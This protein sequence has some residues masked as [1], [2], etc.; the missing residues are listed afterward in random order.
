MLLLSIGISCLYWS[1]QW[2]H[3]MRLISSFHNGI[4]VVQVFFRQPCCWDFRGKAL[5]SHLEGTVLQ[6]T[7]SLSGSSILFFFFCQ[8]TMPFL[9]HNNFLCPEVWFF[10]SEDNDSSFILSCLVCLSILILLPVSLIVLRQVF[11]EYPL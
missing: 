2:W 4:V 6:Q 3:S 5:L 11:I 7:S 8:Y 9:K 1:I 10:S